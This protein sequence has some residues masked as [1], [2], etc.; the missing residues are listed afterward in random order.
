MRVCGLCLRGDH[1]APLVRLHHRLQVP[2]SGSLLVVAFAVN[3][4]MLCVGYLA[5]RVFGPEGIDFAA[6]ISVNHWYMYIYTIDFAVRIAVKCY[7][8]LTTQP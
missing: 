6:R 1:A 4:P 2:F 5:C 7:T 8:I 3:A